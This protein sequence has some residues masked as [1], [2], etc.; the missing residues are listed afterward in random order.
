MFGKLA[1][2]ISS[3]NVPLSASDS[4]AVTLGAIMDVMGFDLKAFDFILVT[5]LSVTS[6]LGS[7]F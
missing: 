3:I 1:S 4:T 6:P 2:V 7:M 5:V